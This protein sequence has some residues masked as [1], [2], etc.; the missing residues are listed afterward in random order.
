MARRHLGFLFLVFLEK[1]RFTSSSLT[2]MN[3]AAN[4]IPNKKQTKLIQQSLIRPKSCGRCS[5][6]PH[7]VLQNENDYASWFL[8]VVVILIPR[9]C[10]WVFYFLVKQSRPYKNC[11]YSRGCKY[12]FD[13]FTHTFLHCFPLRIVLFNKTHK[14]I[15]PCSHSPLNIC[16]WGRG[17]ES[18]SELFISDLLKVT[19]NLVQVKLLC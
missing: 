13:F 1:C 19:F 16:G 2:T 14:K 17:W 4:S 11:G 3:L 10:K 18:P 6:S 8:D 15:F 5:I 12:D 9:M 7:H